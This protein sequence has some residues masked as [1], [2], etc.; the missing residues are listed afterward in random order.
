VREHDDLLLVAVGDDIGVYALARAFH[1]EYRCP[2]VALVG[3]GSTSRRRLLGLGRVLR[4]SDLVT[5][6][7]VADI[8]DPE[9]LVQALE[10]VA[11]AFADRTRVLLTGNDHHAQV[12][13]DHADR[14]RELYLFP[15][16]PPEAFAQLADKE[17]FE[18]VCRR[19]DVATPVTVRVD[20]AEL[21][22]AGGREALA[23]LSVDLEYPVIAKPAVTSEHLEFYDRVDG[24]SK[25]YRLADR[26]A[27][28]DL[29]GRL[30]D[31]GYEGVFL[32]QDYIGGDDTYM[33]L[34]V[35]YR[36]TGGTVTLAATGHVLLEGAEGVMRSAYSRW[37]ADGAAAVTRIL[38]EVGY[39]GLVH[40]NYKCDPR[41]GKNVYLEVN[42]RAGN[43]NYFA[44]AA[45]ANVARAVVDDVVDHRDRDQVRA[46]DD[47]LYGVYPW[48]WVSQY[49]TDPDLREH[50]SQIERR[51]G[52]TSPWK[53]RHD[54]GLRRRY[55]TS[56][57]S[58]LDWRQLV[59]NHPAP[60]EDYL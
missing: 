45:G 21:R 11:E 60:G 4:F 38:D 2:T 51:D 15:P 9:S 28:D 7:E 1:E 6:V 23:D 59:D 57:T 52:M 32:V 34:M 41:T 37:D 46:R 24:W 40:V 56:A 53:Y 54:S 18:Q 13:V 48:R 16:C 26:S 5:E 36:D 47:V 20:L 31:A 25:V 12:L 22:A 14:L 10:S 58:W 39:V 33:R 27:V 49:V 35:G 29:L 50:L 30:L 8:D 44:T 42:P 3:P 19:V 17:K 55:L 43:N